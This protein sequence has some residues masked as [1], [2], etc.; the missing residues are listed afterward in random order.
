LETSD[1]HCLFFS[2]VDLAG[3]RLRRSGRSRVWKNNKHD[4][5]DG[6]NQAKL[7]LPDRPDL[8]FAPGLAFSRI[9]HRLGRGY[10]FFDRLLVGR[11]KRALR[12]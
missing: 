10:G 12:L 11:G 9:R 7:E 1:H 4:S 6:A 2:D 8:T 3:N 5:F